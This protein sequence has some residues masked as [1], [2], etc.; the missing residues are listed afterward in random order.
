[1][2]LIPYWAVPAGE[3]DRCGGKCVGER[4]CCGYPGSSRRGFRHRKKSDSLLKRARSYQINSNQYQGMLP[5]MDLASVNRV[6][7]LATK[8]EEKTSPASLWCRSAN[9][10][11]SSSC[12]IVF[13]DMLRVPP[14]PAPCLSRAILHR[15]QATIN[16]T[17]RQKT[18]QLFSNVLVVVKQDSFC[19][20]VFFLFFC[21]FIW[22]IPVVGADKKPAP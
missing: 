19:V 14:A 12:S 15:P 3:W 4:R 5:G 18:F 6:E 10:A 17:N 1:M 9:S 11:S 16:Q 8:Q 21:F 13:P 2:G 20:C 22:F 7:S